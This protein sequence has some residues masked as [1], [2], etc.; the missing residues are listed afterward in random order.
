VTDT[1]RRG[2]RHDRGE[3]GRHVHRSEGADV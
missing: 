3:I 2:R 1:A